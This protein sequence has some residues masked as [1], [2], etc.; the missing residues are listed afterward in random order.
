MYRSQAFDNSRYH[1]SVVGNEEPESRK[2]PKPRQVPAPTPQA[3]PVETTPN[4]P[5]G[6]VRLNSM[7]APF[8]KSSQRRRICG[9]AAQRQRRPK[10]AGSLCVAPDIVVTNAHVLGMLRGDSLPPTRVQVCCTAA[11][12]A[13]RRPRRLSWASTDQR[14]GSSASSRRFSAVAGA[15]A[16]GFRATIDRDAEGLHFRFPFRR[17][18]GQEHHRQRIVGVVIAP[19]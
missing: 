17:A 5:P 13:R 11:K 15:F 7:P 4:V 10:A 8:A 16:R 2:I 6:P 12:P 9:R 19:Q 14:F 3:P 18:T 1:R